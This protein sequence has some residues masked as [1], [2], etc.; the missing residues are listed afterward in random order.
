KPEPEVKPELELE[1]EPG[2]EGDPIPDSSLNNQDIPTINPIIQSPSPAPALTENFYSGNR[3]GVDVPEAFRASEVSASNLMDFTLPLLSSYESNWQAVLVYEVISQIGQKQIARNQEEWMDQLFEEVFAS[4]RS[5]LEKQVVLQSDLQAGDLL[6]TKQD[7]KFVL[8]GLYLSGDYQAVLLEEDKDEKENED[9]IVL[10]IGLQRF[11]EEQ[12]DDVMIQRLESP[13]LSKHG[14]ELVRDYPAPYD[15]TPNSTTQAFIEEL[16]EDARELGLNYDMFSSVLIAQALLESGSGTSGLSRAPHYN[17]FG[18]KGS[19]Q[20]SSVLLP[21]MEDRGNGDLYEIHAAF[22]SYSGYA[23]S[24]GDYVQLIRGG[25]SGNQDFYKDVWRSESKNYLRATDALTGRYATDV[26]YSKKLNSIIA[27]YDLTKY[28]QPANA[29]TGLF[30]QG[31]EQIPEEYRAMMKN[32]VYNGKDYNTSG[33]YPVGQCTWY[34]FNRV[35]QLGGRVDD[36]MGNGGE[37]GATGRRLG[38]HVSAIP[39]VGSVISFTPGSAGSSPQYGHVA[40]VEAVGPHGILI[41]EG[42]V[43]GGTTISYRVISNE[44]ARSS[45]VTYITPK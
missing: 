43:Y 7:D 1:T 8:S 37:W 29:E 21:T 4:P 13:V 36:Y 34:V 9:E 22:R 28:D 31:I 5:Y 25:I 17:L 24:M 42:N 14:E 27:A 12:R 23:S 16:A 20:G 40:F 35:A 19:Y 39:T 32:P 18:I 6:Y 2:K 26:T 33:S 38:Y 44:L 10:V 3:Q 30:I 45:Q 41:S 11:E 15:F